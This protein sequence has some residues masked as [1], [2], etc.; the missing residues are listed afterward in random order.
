MLNTRIMPEYNW[1]AR[2]MKPKTSYPTVSHCEM[3]LFGSIDNKL[4]AVMNPPQKSGIKMFM[5]KK[6]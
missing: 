5:D 6:K 3:F 4:I 1:R 2:Q